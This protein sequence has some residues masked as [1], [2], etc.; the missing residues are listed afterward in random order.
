[1]EILPPPYGVAAHRDLRRFHHQETQQP[2]ALLADVS[3]PL[4]ITA[5]LFSRDQP[6]IAGHLLAAAKPFRL[7]DDQHKR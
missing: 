6:E 2:V 5:R 3:Q 1:M 4:T 7:P